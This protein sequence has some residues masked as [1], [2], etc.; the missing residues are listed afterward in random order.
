MFLNTFSAGCPSRSY[1]AT[2]KNGNINP[3]INKAAAEPPIVPRVIKYTGTPTTAAE[4]KHT[5][6][7]AVMLKNVLFLILL[8]SFGTLTN[9]KFYVTEKIYM[10]FHV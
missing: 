2:K 1:I 3:I 5:S 8:R 9:A 10:F 4:P 7:L 6:C